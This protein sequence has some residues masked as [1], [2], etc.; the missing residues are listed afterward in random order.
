MAGMY[1]WASLTNSCYTY[2]M[3]YMLIILVLLK[4]LSATEKHRFLVL[5]NL[6]FSN[7]NFCSTGV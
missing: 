3:N 4:Q 7:Y 2:L 1:N 6:G 5:P